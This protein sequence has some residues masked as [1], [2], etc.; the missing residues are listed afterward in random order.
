MKSYNLLVPKANA[1]TIFPVCIFFFAFV[2]TPETSQGEEK[3]L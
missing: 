1:P 2:M 3:D